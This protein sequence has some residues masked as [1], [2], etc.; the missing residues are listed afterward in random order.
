MSRNAFRRVLSP[1]VTALV[2]GG[3]VAAPAFADR[4]GRRGDDRGGYGD[5]GAYGEPTLSMRA[6]VDLVLSRYGGQVVKAEAQSR[7]GQ[8]FYLIRVLTPEG[9]LVRVRVDALSGRMD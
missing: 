1:L 7:D 5:R 6:A 2:V 9:M 8:L 4:D 3:L